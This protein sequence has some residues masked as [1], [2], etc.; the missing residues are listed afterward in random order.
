VYAEVTRFYLRAELHE[1][2]SAFKQ[3]QAVSS[4]PPLT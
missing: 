4:P 2:F 1:C 3:S